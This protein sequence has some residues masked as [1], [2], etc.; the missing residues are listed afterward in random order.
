MILGTKAALEGDKSRSESESGLGQDSFD[1]R[2]RY[3]RR[4]FI[5]ADEF[6]RPREP[7]VRERLGK[8]TG[9]HLTKMVASGFRLLWRFLP[10]RGRAER[11][12]ATPWHQEERSTFYKAGNPVL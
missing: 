6:E 5:Q 7:N 11:S 2:V 12:D 1:H 8:V 4:A 9:K 3:V 10:V